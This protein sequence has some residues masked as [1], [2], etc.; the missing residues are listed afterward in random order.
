[1][2]PHDPETYDT[3]QLVNGIGNILS[4]LAIS[5]AAIAS[6]NHN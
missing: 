2:V 5:T 3:L 4:Q 1:V 6:I